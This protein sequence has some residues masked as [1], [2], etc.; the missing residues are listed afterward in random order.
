VYGING[1]PAKKIKVPGAATSYTVASL[2]VAT[3]SFC[4]DS[5]LGEGSLG[6]VYKANFPNGQVREQFR[7]L[8]WMIFVI[9]KYFPVL[10]LCNQDLLW[11]DL[12]SFLYFSAWIMERLLFILYKDALLIYSILPWVWTF[13]TFDRFTLELNCVHDN[14]YLL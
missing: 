7:I 3:N 6:R 12:A 4:Q 8:T 14:R 2:Q 1:S 10:S 13:F 5:L 9:C 11:V